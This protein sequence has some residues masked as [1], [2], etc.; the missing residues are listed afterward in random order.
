MK[1][2]A[3]TFLLI[4]IGFVRSALKSRSDAPRQGNEGGTEAWLE[5]DSAY[6][7]GLQSVK[8]ND[9]IILLTWLHEG[10]R[11]VLSGH[12]RWDQSLPITGV[13]SMRSPDR[14]NPVG[15]HRVRVLEISGTRLRVAPLEA[16]DGT[17]I[18]D[19]KPVLEDV[20]DS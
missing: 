16:I 4:V 8:T 3:D 15:L 20:Q 18:V 12:P 14:P 17:P 5:I 9:D 10:A 13:F 2:N 19:I 1:L 11:D 7:E 6:A